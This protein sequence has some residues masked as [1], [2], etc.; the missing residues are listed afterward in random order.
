[1]GTLIVLG[2]P[3][4]RRAF[5]VQLSCWLSDFKHARQPYGVASAHDE[6]QTEVEDTLSDFVT[7]S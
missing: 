1:M 4:T 7:A 6:C 5:L 2:G 3:F